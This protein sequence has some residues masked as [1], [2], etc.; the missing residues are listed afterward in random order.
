M[1]EKKNYGNGIIDL[2]VPFLVLILTNF[3]LRLTHVS[4]GICGVVPPRQTLWYS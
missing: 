4:V 1:V 2:A 3:S